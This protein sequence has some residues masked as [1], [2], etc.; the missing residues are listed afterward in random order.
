MRASQFVSVLLVLLG[1][2]T[3][4]ADPPPVAAVRPLF[5]TYCTRCHDAEKEEGGLDFTAILAT[6]DSARDRPK[7]WRRALERVSKGAMP[8]S[9]S[10]QPTPAHRAALIAWLTA[11]A[12]PF[13]YPEAKHGKGELRYVNGV[14]V[15]RVEG[16][17]AEVGEQ[18][19]TL[20]LKPAAGLLNRAE[21][22]FK[23][24]GWAALYPLMLK[25]GNGLVPQF[26]KDHL[27]ELDAAAKAA[28][29]PRDLLVLGATAPDLRKLGGCSALV[30]EPARSATGGPL[31]GRNLDWPP[32]G[33]FTEYALVT[34]Y[35][36]AGKRAF[37]AVGYPGMTG[38]ATGMN[39][40]GLVVADLSV[41][42]ATDGS[43]TLDPTGVPY[44]L[45]LRRVLE[46]CAT[47][48]DAEKLMRSLKHTVRQNVAVCDTEHG[49]VF[50]VTPKTLHVRRSAD[51]VCVC[52]NHFRTEGL[53]ANTACDRYDALAKAAGK[54]GLTVADVAKHL[55]AANQGANTIQTMVFEPAAGKL[56]VALGAGPTTKLPLKT[57][58]VGEWLKDR[59]R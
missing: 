2:A 52:T 54:R 27:T 55:D 14:P 21:Q 56:H 57:L 29:V 44:T 36:V 12:G 16:T 18:I 32:V 24:Q 50:E 1:S 39:D 31:F 33:D 41:N 26:P 28:G 49:A 23:D 11:R 45:A 3:A 58:D 51:A 25:L 30:V 5:T 17:P 10:E 20:A 48:A 53:A 9:D 8:P 35:R 4:P 15:L 40:A 37:V 6:E 42:V 13:R 34:V 22:F 59:T 7:L 47:V 43:P 19:G 38:V 46:E